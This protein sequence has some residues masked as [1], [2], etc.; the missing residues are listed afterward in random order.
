MK[1]LKHDA[2]AKKILENPLAAKEFLDEYLPAD[3]K[4]LVDLN[5]IK[6]E[7]DTFV[8]ES[9]T[10][11]L[12][13][14]V[15]SVKTKDDNK[16]FV[17][18][19]V[20]HKSTSSYWIALKL[21]KYMLLLCERHEKNTDKL[22]LICPI[23]LYNG[24][25][26]YHAPRNLWQLFE[27][28]EQAKKLM[29]EDYV[30]VDVHSMSDDEII[31][32]GHLGMFEYVLKHIHQ[33]DM[34]KLWDRFLEVFKPTIMLDKENG[35]IYIKSFLWY[36]ESK[37]PDEKQKELSEILIKHLSEEEEGNI[38][39][40]IAEKYIEEGV[41]QGVT[42][43]VELTAINMLKHNADINFISKVTGYSVEQILKLKNKL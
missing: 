27:V 32:K 5:T 35:Y 14:L 28:P 22:P 31:E 17:Y 33:R 23:L 34:I 13:D 37:L 24:S 29:T 40:T 11:Q 41:T 38:M 12:S 30:L 6:P 16:A 26:R 39:R 25:E 20:E 36:T 9:L 3:F 2:I 21:W 7:K 15:Y 4:A 8:E 42:R 19:L 43:G 10:R 1:K 18:I